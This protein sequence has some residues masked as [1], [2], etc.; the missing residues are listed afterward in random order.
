MGNKMNSAA[1]AG[2]P[3]TTALPG[4]YGAGSAGQ[5]IGTLQND[6]NLHTDSAIATNTELLELSSFNEKVHIDTVDGASGTAYPL[7]VLDHPV[8]NLTDALSIAAT[9]GI[10]E[11]AVKNQLTILASHLIDNMT[12][13]S[14]SWPAITLNTGVAMENTLFRRV[15][16]YGEFEGYWNTLEDCWV[17]EVTNFSGWVRGG[18]IGEVSLAVGLGGEFGGQSFF[19]N[20]VPLFPGTTSIINA[21][22]NSEISLTNCTDIVTLKSMTAGATAVVGLSGG[23]LIID[24]TCTGGTIVVTGTG[25][26]VNN[27]AVVIDDTGLTVTLAAAEATPIHADVRKVYS[28]AIDG[29]GTEADPWGPV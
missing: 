28:V 26:Y 5:I 8:D 18:S 13:S 7:G 9:N 1:S 29:A 4:A 2:D 14:D 25:S 27:S 22:T 21:N 12:F 24:A 15:S 16:L 3:W 19:D 20:I 10:G 6:I 11:I 17:Y 23:Q